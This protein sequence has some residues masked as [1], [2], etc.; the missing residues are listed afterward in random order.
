M[1]SFANNNILNKAWFKNI[2]RGDYS[3][4]ETSNVSKSKES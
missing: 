3:I 4:V 1:V 2:S